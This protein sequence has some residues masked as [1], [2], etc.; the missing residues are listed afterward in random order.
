MFRFKNNVG[1]IE[2]GWRKCSGIECVCT[3]NGEKEDERERFWAR[4]SK[5]LTGFGSSERVIVLGDRNA[6]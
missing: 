6:R 4:F 3:W 1:E 2:V 5:C